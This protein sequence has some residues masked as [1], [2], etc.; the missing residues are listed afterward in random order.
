MG[1]GSTES[2]DPIMSRPS[3]VGDFVAF[4]RYER[5]WWLIPLIAALLL[6]VTLVLLARQSQLAPF[7]YAAS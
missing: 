7:V 4:L 2:G 1:R 3:P 6:I 5:K